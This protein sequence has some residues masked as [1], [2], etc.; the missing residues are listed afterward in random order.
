MTKRCK[1]CA[2]KL[3]DDGACTNEKCPA[4]KKAAI[5]KAAE[6][7]KPEQEETEKQTGTGRDR[8][9]GGD[10]GYATDGNPRKY[11]N[12]MGRHHGSGWDSIVEF[13]RVGSVFRSLAGC[14]GD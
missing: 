14:Y 6:E 5:D 3:N 11:G 1:I 2:H 4:C 13:F 8:I 10:Y 12:C 9:N 7:S